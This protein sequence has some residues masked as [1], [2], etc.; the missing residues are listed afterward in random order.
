MTPNAHRLLMAAAVIAAALNLRAAVAA[1]SPV[2]G[3]IQADLGLSNTVAGLLTTLPVLCFA[4]TAPL[5]AYLGKRLGLNTAIYVFLLGIVVGSALRG[6]GGVA[7]LFTGTLVV[8]AAIT[9]GNVLLPVVV[10]RDFPRHVGT[11]TGLFTAAL[12]GGAAIAAATTAPLA[13]AGG[14]ERGL[15]F[16]AVPAVAAI[17]VWWAATGPTRRGPAQTPSAP[18]RS[19]GERL[20]TSRVAWA[21]TIF[22][23]AQSALY[24]AVTAWLP[25]ML[26]DTVALD[27]QSA[28]LAMSIFQLVGIGAAL[29]TPMLAARSTSQV[30]LALVMC[31]M[32]IVAL[33]GLMVAPDAWLVWSVIAGLTQGGNIALAFSLI[34][35]RA[36]DSNVAR[37]LSGMAQGFGYILGASG[38]LLVG[39]IVDAT[40][41]WQPAL[42]FMLVIGGVMAMASLVAG[43]PTVVGDPARRA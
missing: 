25:S 30:P 12:T 13:G 3:E 35:M 9:V 6:V 8:G 22:F 40:G 31:A 15:A 20:W 43:R 34:A 4:L 23:G 29:V 33:A 36:H 38:P 5:A 24:Y 14:W 10:K 42:A 27:T 1:V 37:S 16:W 32:W 28:G 41:D 19:G 2:L 11:M 39:V 21:L 26:T 7:T 17:A 18:L